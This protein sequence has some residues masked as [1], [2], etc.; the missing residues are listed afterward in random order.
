MVFRGEG[1]CD[2]LAAH[3]RD[4]ALEGAIL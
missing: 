4:A 1:V 2:A 3:W